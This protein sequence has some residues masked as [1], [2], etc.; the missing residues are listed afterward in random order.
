[1]IEAYNLLIKEYKMKIDNHKK[2]QLLGYESSIKE[3]QNII[4]SL[5]SDILILKKKLQYYIEC[6][7]PQPNFEW[8]TWA[9]T[10]IKQKS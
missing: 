6:P 4:A 3:C 9:S 8:Q 10:S 2:T 7:N 5:E 1:M